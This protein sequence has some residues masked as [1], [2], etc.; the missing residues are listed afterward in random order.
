MTTWTVRL[1]RYATQD[2]PGAQVRLQ[3][4]FDRWERF[5]YHVLLLES[6][7]RRVLVDCGMDEL[8]P[9]NA[10]LRATVG[11]RGLVRSVASERPVETLLAGHGVRPDDVE[12]IVLTHCHAD[13]VW[14]VD[15]FPRAR[16]LVSREAF[17]RLEDVAARLPQLLPPPLY[18]AHALG[19]LRAARGGRVELVEDGPTSIDGIAIRYLGGHAID[20]AG[21]TI[22]T[23]D[24]L[25]VHPGDTVW[26]YRNLEDDHPVGALEDVVRC[27][28][29]MAWTRAQG[30]TFLPSHDPLAHERHPDGVVA[31]G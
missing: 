12:A 20:S 17:L 27:L 25:V 6:G 26:T 23:G 3:A 19:F 7:D 11:E 28:E 13:H 4:G 18:P 8:E 29:A 2:V 30:G 22:A 10:F 14:N 9:F 21:V 16:V 31:W 1:L 24:G 5:D 15:R